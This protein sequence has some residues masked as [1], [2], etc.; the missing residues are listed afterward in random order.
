MPSR[1]SARAKVVIVVDDEDRENEGDFVTA[2]RQC[3]TGGDQ[4][5]GHTRPRADLRTTD[6]GTL[7]KLGLDLMVQRQHRLARN[8]RSR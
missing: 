3:Y 7:L 4:L 8:A 2:A 6:R 1:I 5:H